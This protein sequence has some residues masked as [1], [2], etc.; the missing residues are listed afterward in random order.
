MSNILDKQITVNGETYDIT[1]THS[2]IADKVVHKLTIETS[3]GNEIE[4]DGSSEKNISVVEKTGG[5]FSG[6]IKIDTN[7][8]IGADNDVPTIKHVN[9]IVAALTGAPLL[10][11]KNGTLET[12]KDNKNSVLPIKVVYGTK[13]DFQTFSM[14]LQNKKDKKGY[15]LYLAVLDQYVTAY[16]VNAEVTAEDAIEVSTFSIG[17]HRIVATEAEETDGTAKYF[18]Y[19][20][21]ETTFSELYG[22]ISHIIDCNMA[23]DGTYIG[24]RQLYSKI[25]ALGDNLTDSTDGIWGDTNNYNNGI[26]GLRQWITDI[27]NGTNSAS[28][29][30]ATNANNAS[31]AEVA[32]KDSDSLQINHN[33]YRTTDSAAANTPHSIHFSTEDPTTTKNLAEQYRAQNAAIGDIWIV[34]K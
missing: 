21:I 8:S 11:W 4:F 19:D 25:N 27:V 33:Y 16:L 2:D 5:T 30:K 24:L 1:A 10:S 14:Y 20:M 28:V 34:Y 7:E 15:Y 31:S 26:N 3:D 12:I 9:D 29:A 6:P 17:S 32:T 18:D 13:A 23:D 22:K